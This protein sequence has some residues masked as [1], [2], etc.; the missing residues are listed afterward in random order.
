[1]RPDRTY[2]HVLAFALEHP[3]AITES[4]A[5]VVAGILARRLA[6]H[7][8]DPLELQALSKRRNLPQPVRGGVAV[9]PFG[10]VVAPRMNMFSEISG[11]TTFEGL[12]AQL[13][14]ALANDAV[15]TIIFDVDSPGGNVAGASEFAAEVLKARATKPIVAVA[16]YLMASAAYWPMACATQLVAAPSAMVGSIGVVTIHDDITEALKQEGITREILS[17]GKFKHEA[18][19]TGALADDER[20]HLKAM[21]DATYTRMVGDI[22]KGR[23]VKASEIRSGYGQGRVLLAEDALAAGMIDRIETLA[24]T[25]ARY[26]P[27][28]TAAQRAASIDPSLVATDQEPLT[29]ATSQERRGDIAWQNAALA[30]LLQLDF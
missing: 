25:I 26:S 23:G 21:L 30:E 13:H 24:D 19:N 16:Q 5:T 2:D 15:K 1:M 12:T 17:A 9:I 7:D 20:A 14:Q 4:M 29:A 6:G 10:G 8:A 28:Q 22:A 18:V 3:W 27:T 11:G